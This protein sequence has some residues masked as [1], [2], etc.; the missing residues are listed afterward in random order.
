MEISIFSFRHCPSKMRRVSVASIKFIDV[1]NKLTK[2]KLNTEISSVST[3]KYTYIV[4]VY[5]VI[6]INVP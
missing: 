2:T 4:P 6:M 5:K 1:H 3:I